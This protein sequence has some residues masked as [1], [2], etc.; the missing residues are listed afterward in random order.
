MNHISARDESVDDDRT[1][2]PALTVEFEGHVWRPVSGDEVTF[3]RAA[4][5]VVDP[6]NLS[7]HRVLG[8][9]RRVDRRWFLANVGRSVSL[10]A[11]DT[12]GAS[13]A[14]IAPGTEVPLPFPRTTVKFSAGR[15]NYRL[16]IEV[17][18]ATWIGDTTD[19]GAIRPNTLERTLTSSGLVFN[20]EQFALLC[21]LAAPRLDGPITSADLPSN[22][23]L[24]R[25]LGWSP[26]KLTRKLDHLCAKFA[27]VGVN[28]LVGSTA[29]T[30]TERRL[31]LADLAVEHRIVTRPGSDTR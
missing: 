7:L 12:D 15:A 6:S 23:Q 26:A 3:G 31:L 2:S 20:E 17:D 5:I 9:I 29:G 21:A 16:T 13:F 8:R 1:N 25:Q 27:R 30:A 14:R 10:V 4:D 22:R 11:S 28:G 24:A 18:P 19:D